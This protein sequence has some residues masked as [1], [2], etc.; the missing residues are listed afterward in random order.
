MWLKALEKERTLSSYFVKVLFPRLRMYFHM[1]LNLF[2]NLKLS[3]IIIN[4]SSNK[5]VDN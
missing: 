4:C 5:K 2:A 3:S 1:Y